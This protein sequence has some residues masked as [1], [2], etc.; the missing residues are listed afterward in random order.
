MFVFHT[1]LISLTAPR[2]WADLGS[3][4]FGGCSHPPP[5]CPCSA[6]PPYHLLLHSP[7]WKGPQR[8]FVP[9]DIIPL[10]GSSQHYHLQ[11]QLSCTTLSPVTESLLAYPAGLLCREREGGTKHHTLER[12]IAVPLLPLWVF[13]EASP[14]GPTLPGAHNGHTTQ[15]QCEPHTSGLLGG[16]KQ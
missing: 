5:A 2:G 10:R 7:F 13:G 11:K 1:T 3:K 9:T 14:A 12:M 15:T 8:N 4:D 6:H 16:G